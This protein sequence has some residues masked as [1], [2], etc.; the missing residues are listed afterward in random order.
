[1]EIQQRDNKTLAAYGH[2][3]EAE[4][5]RCDFNSD[6]TAICIFVKDL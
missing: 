2:W 6:T 5:K 1:M 3:F 4:A